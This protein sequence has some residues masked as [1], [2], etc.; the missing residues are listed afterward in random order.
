MYLVITAVVFSFS[1]LFLSASP[2]SL[3]LH[4][5]REELKCC[6]NVCVCLSIQWPWACLI[7]SPEKREHC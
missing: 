1:F 3:L 5:L 7:R 4:H 6:Q 2:Y